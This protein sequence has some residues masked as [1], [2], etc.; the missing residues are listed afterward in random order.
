MG[1]VDNTTIQKTRNEKIKKNEE[2]NKKRMKEA[3]KIE[4]LPHY[5]CCEDKQ[6]NNISNKKRKNEK[7]SKNQI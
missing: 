7:K 5:P 2:F 3:K 4:N 6:M 1:I